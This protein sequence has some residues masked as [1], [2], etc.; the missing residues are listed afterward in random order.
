VLTGVLGN[1]P[2]GNGEVYASRLVLAALK[3]AK[4]SKD[5][6]ETQ[7]ASAG[8]TG[9]PPCQGHASAGPTGASGTLVCTKPVASFTLSAPTGDTITYLAGSSGTRTF[10]CP[11]DSTGTSATCTPSEGV[12][13]NSTIDVSFQTSPAAMSGGTADFSFAFQDGSWSTLAVPLS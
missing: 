1:G 8:S 3:H 4:K 5:S 11:D 2:G 7:L 10:T 6:L 9:S 12:A 13:A